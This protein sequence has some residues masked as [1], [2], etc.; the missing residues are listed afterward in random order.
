[1]PTNISFCFKSAVP[2][3]LIFCQIFI[4]DYNYGHEGELNVFC[5]QYDSENSDVINKSNLTRLD[6]HFSIHLK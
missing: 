1:M 5:N 3:S 2:G 4:T 6:I